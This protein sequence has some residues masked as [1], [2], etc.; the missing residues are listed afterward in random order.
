MATTDVLEFIKKRRKK[1]RRRLLGIYDPNDGLEVNTIMFAPH[2]SLLGSR[3]S[4]FDNVVYERVGARNLRAISIARC[5]GRINKYKS[6]NVNPL[7]MN[8]EG[9]G[10][11]DDN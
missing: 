7:K 8:L 3:M 5:M 11:N 6:L 1:R 9:K 10:H 4:T 2:A